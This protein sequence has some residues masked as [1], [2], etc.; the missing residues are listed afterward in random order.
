MM[1][2]YDWDIAENGSERCRQCRHHGNC[3]WHYPAC[4]DEQAQ[5]DEEDY[6]ERDVDCPR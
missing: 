3:R 4:L 1:Y 5:P 6:D 2:D